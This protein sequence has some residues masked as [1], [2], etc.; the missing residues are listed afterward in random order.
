MPDGF[1]VDLDKFASPDALGT[2][3]LATKVD[4]R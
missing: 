4:N 2:T 3:G 1:S